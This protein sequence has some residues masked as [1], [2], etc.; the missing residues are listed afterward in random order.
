MTEQYITITE[1]ARSYLQE[2]LDKQ[3]SAAMGVRIFVEQPGTPY[4]E[5]CMAYC[6]K[7]EQEEEDLAQN[8]GEFTAWIESSSVPYLED[9]VIDYAKERMGGQLTF[10][11]PK[12]KVPRVG[13][14]A[15]IEERINYIL[16]SEV[17]PSLASHGG[18]VSL[19]ELV[20][21]GETAVLRFGGGCQGCAAVDITLKQG[22]EKSLVGQVP[23]LKRVKDITDHSNTD[24]AYY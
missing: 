10:R 7:N 21:D 19:V 8:C 17:N 16:Y 23:G 5:C 4:A 3:E 22:V 20:D 6:A 15:S 14:D 2:L 9:A 24:H 12:S 11:A 1:S 13:E 18:Q